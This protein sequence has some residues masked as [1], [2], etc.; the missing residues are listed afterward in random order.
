MDVTKVYMH[1]FTI[2]IRVPLGYQDVNV[3][4]DCL[5]GDGYGLEE[6]SKK[7]NP[8]LVLD[9]GGH[10]GAFGL[11]A[12]KL[13]PDCELIAVEP[14]R[15]S[16]ELYRENLKDNGFEGTVINKGI[17]YNPERNKLVHAS[18]TSG[19]HILLSQEEAGDYTD[20]QYRKMENVVEDVETI[21]IE[22][23]IKDIDVVDLAKW[24]CEGAEIDAFRKMSRET[25]AKF[26]TM[27]GEYHLWGDGV[28][29]LQASPLDEMDFWAK[30]KR[31][32]P[33]LLWNWTPFVANNEKYGKFQAWPKGEKR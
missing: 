22:E 10:I 2:N 29:V 9:M 6:L 16:C 17:C 24:D 20:A 18:R 33:H 27:V 31:K 3:I 11:Y 30:A 25:A 4:S 19:G 32:F 13:W 8:K 7:L 12:K 15:E 23:L 14:C 5:G 28:R 21:T 1:G 26:R